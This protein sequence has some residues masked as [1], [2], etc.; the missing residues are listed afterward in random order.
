MLTKRQATAKNF[1]GRKLEI[2]RDDTLVKE[3]Y[4]GLTVYGIA[5]SY[6]EDHDTVK[7]SRSHPFGERVDTIILARASLT[8]LPRRT[9]IYEGKFKT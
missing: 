4:Q 2:A 8:V 9:R 5:G 7:V 1:Q 6:N 3:K